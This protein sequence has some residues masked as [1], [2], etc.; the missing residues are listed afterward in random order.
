MLM[1]S[2]DKPNS[3]MKAMDSETLPSGK[4]MAARFCDYHAREFGTQ[5][6]LYQTGF[7]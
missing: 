6:A 7:N 1:R 4:Q 3:A 5:A 2:S